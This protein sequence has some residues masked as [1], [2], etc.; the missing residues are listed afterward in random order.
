MPEGF[1]RGRLDPHHRPGY[2]ECVPHKEEAQR[3]L[4]DLSSRVKTSFDDDRTILSFREWLEILLKDPARN[5]RSSSQYIRDVFDH[6]GTVERQL[7]RGPV[8]RYRLFDAPWSGGDG[9]VAGQESVQREIYRLVSNFVRDGRVTKLVLLHGPNGSAKSSMVRCL[10]EGMANYSRTNEGALYSYAWIFPSEKVVK[11]RLG[12]DSR[13]D[14]RPDAS[15]SFAHL[16]SEQVDARLPCEL[17]DHP[18]FLIPKAERQA[19]LEK[20]R[21]EGRLA[22]DFVL[23]RYIMEGDLSPRDRAIYDALLLAHDGDHAAVLKHIQVHRFFVSRIY[24][25]AVATVEPQMHVDADAKQL[26]ADRSIVNL[27]RALQSVPMYEILGPLV[28]ANRG[29]LEYSDLLKRPLEAFKYLLTTSEEASASLPQFRIYLDE[30]LIAS[31]NEKQLEA[32]KQHPDWN[33]FKGRIELVRVPYLLRFS[34][35]VEIY[36]SQIT[37]VSIEKPLAP[38][39]VEVA[40][41]WAVLS[42]LKA[43]N[44]EHF[45]GT[46]ESIAKKLTPIE[47]L[48]LYDTGE[49]PS[50]VSASNARELK[51]GIRKILDEYRSVLSYEGQLGASAREIRTLILNAAHR[52]QYQCLTPLPI[53]DEL[54]DFI[55]DPTLYEFLQQKP[56]NGFHEHGA[57]VKAVR[58]WWLDV[59]DEELRTSMGLVEEARLDDLFSKYILHVSHLMKKEKLFDKVTGHYVDPDKDL[60]KDVEA[61]ILAEGEDRVDFRKAIIGRIGAW[62]LDHAGETPDYRVLFQNY[63]HRMEE[64]YYNRQRKVIAKNLET[65]LTL[66]RGGRSRLSDEEQASADRTVKEM[67]SRYGYDQRCTQECAAYLLKTRYRT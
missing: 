44:P 16:P 28:S 6:F 51:Q 37:P 27:P 67:E 41:L 63:I 58:T 21:S 57:F 59:L 35:E 43:P 49:V 54:D 7:P 10:H 14:D 8:S 32:F 62:S 34:D 33:S 56:K 24:G 29:M 31:T 20:L 50:W 53:F 23:S 4:S 18:I 42:R 22:E 66:L 65:T 39:V 60:M 52:P 12:F 30:I 55:R 1:S 64:D 45:S 48:K 38:H 13:D 11:G 36:R 19:M 46:L 15:E 25:R 2:T 61:T 40:A 47:K 17:R 5:L 9:R 3:L 26:T